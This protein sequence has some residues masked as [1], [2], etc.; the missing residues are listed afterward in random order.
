MI[1]A[2]LRVG[3]GI[4]KGCHSQNAP[5]V[6]DQLAVGYGRARVENLHVAQGLGGLYAGDLVALLV[7]AR[8]AA[9]AHHHAHGRARVPL[10]SH[11]DQAV[12]GHGD[13]R[14]E[15]VALEAHD[16]RLALRIAEAAVE[17]DDLWPG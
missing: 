7:V 5:A 16:E 9:A 11:L 3:N 12:L 1:R 14:L 6:G 13:H 10:E 15:Q 17:L 8:V 2:F 4:A